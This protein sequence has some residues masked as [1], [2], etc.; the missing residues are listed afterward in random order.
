M[1]TFFQP[2]YK[3]LL[4]NKVIFDTKG[5]VNDYD[6]ALEPQVS[7]EFITAARWFHSMQ[8]GRIK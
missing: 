7:Y 4:E 2:G 5:H 8:D 6:E 3:F 1:N